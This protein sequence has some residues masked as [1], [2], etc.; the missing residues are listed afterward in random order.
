[1][2]SFEL[3]NNFFDFCEQQ[4]DNSTNQHLVLNKTPH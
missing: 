2:I 4:T 1:M 3:I